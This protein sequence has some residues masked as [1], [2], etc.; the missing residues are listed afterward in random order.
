M[1]AI[2]SLMRQ[3]LRACVLLA[4]AVVLGTAAPPPVLPSQSGAPAVRAWVD[5]I[6]IPTYP[7]GEADPNPRFRAFGGPPIYPYSMQDRFGTRRAER[8]YRAVWLENEY[9]RVLCLPELGGRIQSVFDKVADRE[10]FYRNRV[11]RPGHIA[12]RGAWV[13]GGIE[14]N[15]GPEGHGVTSFSPV[16]VRITS[17][18]DGSA[19]LLIGTVEQVGRTGWEVE[20]TLHPGRRQL[21]ERVL[22]YNPTDAPRP[23]YFWNNT[24]FPETAGTRFILPM[25]L[26]TDHDGTG[27][28]AW[29]EHEGRD[30]TWLR[31]YPEPTS[32]F[33]YR[34]EQD[35]FGAYD[36]DA[37]Y[38]IVQVA[39]HHLLPGKKA[40]TWGTADEG[41]VA[42]AALTDEDGPYIEVQSGPLRTQSDFAMLMPGQEISWQELWYPVDGFERG[43]EYAGRHAAVE[44][45]AHDDRVELRI[46]ATAAY[47]GS[48][49][50]VTRRDGF[51]ARRA[52][53]LR[54]GEIE[55]ISIARGP[56]VDPA[57]MGLHV[58]LTSARG[59][60]LLDYE[61]PLEPVAQ[62]I[63]EPVNPQPIGTADVRYRQGWA[64]QLRG[65]L[66][67][68]A[69]AYRNA[70]ELDPGHGD[71]LRWLA[72]I[73]LQRARTGAALELL[74]RA[75]SHDRS[76]GWTHYLWGVAHLREGDPARAEDAGFAALRQSETVALGWSLVG[77][78]RA[79]AGDAAGAAEAF[80]TAL[81][82]GGG[83]WTRLF[84]MLLVA[85][86]AAG[87]ADAASTIARQ[88]TAAGTLRL[89]PHLLP[90]LARESTLAQ[91]AEAAR[92]WLGEPDFAFVEASLLFHDLGL[93]R[94]AARLLEAGAASGLDP[95]RRHPVPLWS[96]AWYHHRAGDEEA[97]E[98]WLD[99]AAASAASQLFPSRPETLPV[100][101]WVLE[102]RPDSG[103]AHEAFGNLLAGLER[104]DDAVAAWTRAAELDPGLSIARRNLGHHAWKIDEDLDAAAAW[105][106]GALAARPTDQTLVRDLARV[107]RDAGRGSEAIDLLERL[108]EDPH[109]RTDVTLEL[110]DAYLE[111]GRPDDTLQLLA[112]TSFVNR[113]GSR[114]PWDLHYRA[115][116]ERG[117]EALAARPA[118][119]LASYEAALTYPSNLGVGRP[120]RPTEGAAWLGKG[121]AL[122]ALGRTA[123]AQRAF[124]T[125]VDLEPLSDRERRALEACESALAPDR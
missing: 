10:M 30:L 80:T 15:R 61:S 110:A 53:D 49:L 43:F 124:R 63:P 51:V 71:S 125:C 3:A 24:A 33:G 28:F 104:M 32:V 86:W 103:R 79:R 17:R 117:D 67:G 23:Y 57:T 64:L 38:G 66:E 4:A 1:D 120:H 72:S 93:D 5:T 78:A 13:S 37:R 107:L 73:E 2:P 58:R 25:T 26:G 52:L 115:W 70:L 92:G 35:F 100:L 68:A 34:V 39:D 6:T 47:P 54:P 122:A 48:T 106:R 76:N 97:A 95:A 41:R 89:I 14:W 121:R 119:A 87:D 55:T 112:A 111:A 27:F 118:D 69:A 81:S 101:E 31:N 20:L 36:V 77:R 56:V 11:I 62:T 90:A 29:P 75:L 113:E 102:R 116:V 82:V 60:V 46:A 7:L 91:A 40:W 99:A 44:R 98:R 42:Q 18:S 109:R 9:L 50:E 85:T 88:A 22:L 65:D 12:L 74:D 114:G 105:L 19:S 96:L 21:D 123:E 94:A 84:D 45:L 16:D 59:A 8:S 83:N 108:L